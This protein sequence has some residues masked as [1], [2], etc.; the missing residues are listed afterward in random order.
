MRVYNNQEMARTVRYYHHFK[1]VHL[2]PT[3]KVEKKVVE[4]LLHSKVSDEKRDS[5]IVFEL[6]H[7]SECIQVARILAQK[8]GL[9]IALAEAAAAL[10]DI[11]VIVV[12]SY[13]NHAKLGA[14]MAIKI[15]KE[16][17]GF[18]QSEIQTISDA[19]YHHSEKEIYT[20]T[21]YIELIK[22]ADVFNCSFYRNSEAEYRSIKTPNVFACY[23]KRVMGVRRELG[24]PE[25]PVFRT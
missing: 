8:R 6:K 19:V 10:H 1:G 25:E 22:D 20:D 7:S 15:L 14:P 21:P 12:G 16:V 18:T 13:S 17:G 9:N 4:L 11:Y 24:L 5:S 3:E 23:E 2:S